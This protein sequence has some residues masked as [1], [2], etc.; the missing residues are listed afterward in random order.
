[1]VINHCSRLT[2]ILELYTA[3]LFFTPFASV[4]METISNNNE[5]QKNHSQTAQYKKDW[6][7]KKGKQY[8]KI[9]SSYNNEDYA[10]ISNIAKKL[11]KNKSE[12]VSLDSMRA[13]REKET[14]ASF[15][16]FSL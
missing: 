11:N 3:F 12:V 8:K 13:L 4:Y 9:A 6:W 15:T 10:L 7:E 16:N 2:T 1:M 14:T 5:P